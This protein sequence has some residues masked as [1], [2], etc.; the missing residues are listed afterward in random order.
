MNVIS[1]I[2][3]LILVSFPGAFIRWI[4]T[5]FKRPFKEILFEDGNTN[6][7]IGILMF[8]II[9]VVVCFPVRKEYTLAEGKGLTAQYCSS[10][11]TKYETRMMHKPSLQ[12]M[13]DM[14]AAFKHA[15][16]QALGDSNHYVAAKELTGN[17]K[18]II[19]KY[20]ASLERSYEDKRVR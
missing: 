15:Y 18:E 13:S 4:F 8:I 7:N 19:Y 20:I 9:V 14:K 17:E 16:S 12:Q 11:H 2:L 5:G 10:C 1:E 3:F 6:E